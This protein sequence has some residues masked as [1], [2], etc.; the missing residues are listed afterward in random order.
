MPECHKNRLGCRGQIRPAGA[1]ER[2]LDRSRQSVGERSQ[3]R[4]DFVGRRLRHDDYEFGVRVVVEP[5]ERLLRCQTTHRGAEVTSADAERRAQADARVI[6]QAHQLLATR[7][8]GRDEPDRA[9]PYGIGETE[10]DAA[11]HGGPAIGAHHQQPALLRDPLEGDLLFHRNVVT[12]N[13]DVV[14]LIECVHRL[15]DRIL[16]GHGNHGQGR[17]ESGHRRFGRPGSDVL[18]GIGSPAA[19]RGGEGGL[20]GLECG[21]D[22]V[23]GFDAERNNHVVCR[24]LGNREAHGLEQAEVQRRRHRHL[25]V[26]HPG[27]CCDI[28]AHLKQR[29]RVGV[30]ALADFDMDDAGSGRWTGHDRWLLLLR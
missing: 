28:F 18:F 26:P 29:H 21:R 9:G 6:E 13:H 3:P 20:D 25:S 19:G 2:K 14:A 7:A 15:H 12:E 17:V 22:P 27:G 4:G 16:S 30:C 24:G 11:D 23:I 5:S 10:S 8:R 1:E